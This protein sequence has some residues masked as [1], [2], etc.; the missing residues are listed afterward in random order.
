MAQ[1]DMYQ[2][3][4]RAMVGI[5]LVFLVVIALRL[6]D[7]QAV[8]ASSISKRATNEM[9]M[10]STLLAPRGEIT[11][12]NGVE[13]ARSVD[14]ITVVV[15]QTMIADPA[16]TASVVAPI[17]NIAAPDLQTLLTGTK[18]YQIVAKNV[19]PAV[20]QNLQTTLTNYNRC[21]LYTSPSP[22]D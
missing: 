21:L 22:R 20:W 7:V 19:A 3:R 12:I 13:L 8:Q 1:R 2:R 14:A 15:D 5:M 10:T 11:D 9:M 4:I 16:T 6:V 17:L 18:R